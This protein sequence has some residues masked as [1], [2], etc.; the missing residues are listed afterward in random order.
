LHDAVQS[1]QHSTPG[2]AIVTDQFAHGAAQVAKMR[3]APD[4]RFAVVEHPLGSL[5][6]EALWAR[7]EEALP[8]VVAIATGRE[9]S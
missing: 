2:V 3:G 8:Q 4:L 6:E 7:A 5:D 9:L 1:E